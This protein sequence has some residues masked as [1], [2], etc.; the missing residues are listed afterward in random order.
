MT[1]GEME[2]INSLKFADQVKVNLATIPYE[3]T[4]P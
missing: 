2:L 1:S 4:K 3:S